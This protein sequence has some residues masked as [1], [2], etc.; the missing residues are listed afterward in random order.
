VV[1]SAAVAAEELAELLVLVS[2]L[3]LP[4]LVSST[5]KQAAVV[6]SAEVRGRPESRRGIEVVGRVEARSVDAVEGVVVAEA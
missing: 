4:V 1:Q 3:G 2:G 5:S 6:R